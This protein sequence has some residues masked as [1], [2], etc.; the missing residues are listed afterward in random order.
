MASSSSCPPNLRS[1]PYVGGPQFVFV[2]PIVGQAV[3]GADADVHIVLP[4]PCRYFTIASILTPQNSVFFHLKQLNKTY[5][6]NAIVPT[7]KEQWI[8]MTAQNV[9]TAAPYYLTEITLGTPIQD[10]YLDTGHENGG[11]NTITLL[12]AA[13]P[14]AITLRGGAYT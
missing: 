5:G 8:S 12:C 1:R 9:T 3:G 7:G 4:F 6:S 14:D 10:F 13:E 2:G 11:A